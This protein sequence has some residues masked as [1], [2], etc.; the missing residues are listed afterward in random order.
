MKKY[1]IMRADDLGFCEAVN[2]GIAK[3]VRKGPV[4]TAGLMVNMDAAEHGVKLLAGTGCC[5]GLHCNISVGRPICPPEKVPTLVNEDGKFYSSSR[6]RAGENFASCE[7]LRREIRAQYERYLVLVGEKPSYIEAHA[8]M[9][10]N[11]EIVIKEMAQEYGLLYQPPFADMKVMGRTVKMCAMHSMEVGYDAKM[12]VRR[13]LS[14][15]QDDA[16]HVY[17]CHPGYLDKYLWDH[18]SLRLPRMDEVEM[19][20]DP[21]LMDWME[22]EAVCG[23]TYD[24]L[25]KI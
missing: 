18:S 9:C 15:I 12:A 8:V 19:L 1:V 3:T 6:Y 4:R 16:V 23:V 2:H 17:V 10:E 13:E 5:L 7:D 25:I 24:D 14:E 22:Q 20:C 21:A 11:M